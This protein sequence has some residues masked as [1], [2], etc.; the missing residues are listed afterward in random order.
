M[1]LSLSLT[2]QSLTFHFSE[3]AEDG[4]YK[5]KATRPLAYRWTDKTIPYEFVTSHFSEFAMSQLSQFVTS[6]FNEGDRHDT[7]LY[8]YEIVTKHFCWHVAL[9]P[10]ACDYS[11]PAQ[12]AVVVVVVVVNLYKHLLSASSQGE[13]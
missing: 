9:F 12:F 7:I 11:I 6:L 2:V 5:R 4:R 3:K 10:P 1:C 13:P 8:Q